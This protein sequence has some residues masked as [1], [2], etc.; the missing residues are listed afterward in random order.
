MKT[1][2]T[3]GSLT[4]FCF[5]TAA[6]ALVQGPAWGQ[7][8]YSFTAN[9]GDFSMGPSWNNSVTPPTDGSAI[10]DFSPTGSVSYSATNDLPPGAGR[11]CHWM[12]STST[13][14]RL[15]SVTIYT[16]SNNFQVGSYGIVQNGSTPITFISTTGGT[17]GSAI[18]NINVNNPLT[19]G[20]SGTGTVTIGNSLTQNTV[21]SGSGNVTVNFTTTGGSANPNLVLGN[22]ADGSA[23]A[24][25][26][27]SGNISVVSGYVMAGQTGGNMWSNTTIVNIGAAGTYNM[28]NNGE[29][30]GS[31]TGN[32]NLVMGNAGLDSSLRRATIPGAA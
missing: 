28:N 8:T 15:G 10:L 14:H 24:G 1:Y 32:G 17:A 4:L 12:V 16:G 19:I 23:V 13:D 31:L 25:E 5:I 3:A 29:T 21:F 22:I 26:N 20:G 27:F 6:L 9:S 7:T 30:F 11:R 2:R 18:F